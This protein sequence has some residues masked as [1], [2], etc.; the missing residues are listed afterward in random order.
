MTKKFKRVIARLDVKGPNVV[1]GVQMEGLRVLG[2]PEEFA[3][4]YYNQ[5]ADEIIF[6]DIVASLYGRNNLIDV[7]SKTAKNIFIPLIV[8][9]GIRTLKD[10][11]DL[12]RAGADKIS[13]NS[14]AIKNP[15]F[16]QEA[17]KEFG[18]STI[19]ISVEVNF[20]NNKY[21]IFYNNGR[22]P[23]NIDLN[24]WI[25][26]CQ[27]RG[28]GEILLSAIHKDGTGK[29]YDTNLIEQVKEIVYIPLIVQGGAGSIKDIEHVS[30]YEI[31]GI[32]LSS[33]LHYT[34]ISQDGNVYREGSL[35]GN[36]EFLK[37]KKNFLNFEKL[38]IEMIKKAVS[39]L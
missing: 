15:K 35:E 20:L 19:T 18:S 14:A 5:N 3:E 38:N 12:L 17:V 28:A 1:K 11:Y 33:A 22:E 39:N 6:S 32:V 26:E 30:N 25:N 4:Y 2:Q 21:E 31:D 24:E 34:K 27:D 36:K 16:I 37:S 23:A 7:V 10:I 13:L 8:G 29:G 9:G